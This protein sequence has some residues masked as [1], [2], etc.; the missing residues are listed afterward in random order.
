MTFNDQGVGMYTYFLKDHLGN[1]RVVIDQNKTVQ[2]KTDYYPFGGTAW[3]GSNSSGNKYLYNGKE[4]QNDAFD[5]NGDD[6]NDVAL[7]WYD[8]APG[9]MT[10]RLEG[11]MHQIQWLNCISM[12]HLIIIV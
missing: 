7:D 10:H 8:S 9:S 6:I 11:G 3:I 4:L 1:T 5:L 12:L 2:Q